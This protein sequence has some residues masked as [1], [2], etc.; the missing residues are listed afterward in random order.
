MISVDGQRREQEQ[1]DG[2]D[3]QEERE[4]PQQEEQTFCGTHF[5]NRK[6]YFV[7]FFC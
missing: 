3:E 2:R 6:T 4:G 1:I 7:T 5:G